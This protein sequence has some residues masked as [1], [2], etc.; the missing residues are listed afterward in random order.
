MDI[1]L[2]EGERK[3]NAPAELV[4][5][6]TQ[7]SAGVDPDVKDDGTIGDGGMHARIAPYTSL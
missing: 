6:N 4:G 5:A 3:V 2:P 7:V 1:R